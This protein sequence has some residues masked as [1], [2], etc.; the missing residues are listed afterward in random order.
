MLSFEELTRKVI[1]ELY[2]ET[3]FLKIVLRRTIQ[4]TENRS[5]YIH[6]LYESQPIIDECLEHMKSQ[7]SFLQELDDAY[8][9][10]QQH[11]VASIDYIMTFLSKKMGSPMCAPLPRR[12]RSVH[13]FVAHTLNHEKYELG[14][15]ETSNYS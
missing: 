5:M 15:W 14:E 3:L 6:D 8:Y 1:Y 13:P 11:G 4:R 12:T 10:S 7:T 9:D 2:G